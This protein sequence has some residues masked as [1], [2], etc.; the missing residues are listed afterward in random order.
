MLPAGVWIALLAA[1]AL[2]LVIALLLLRRDEAP[3]PLVPDLPLDPIAETCRLIETNHIS[4]V[5]QC[6]RSAFFHQ[7][8]QCLQFPCTA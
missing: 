5:L 3:P 6:M 4:P 1:D 8:T 2:V 7:P